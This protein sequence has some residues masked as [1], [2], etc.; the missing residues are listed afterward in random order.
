MAAVDMTLKLDG[1]EGES[2]K[3][4]H[5][6]EIDILSYSFGAT[7]SGTF[8]KGGGGGAGL[9][10][11]QDMVCTMEHNKASPAIMAACAQGDHVASAVLTCRKAGKEQQDFL[12]ITLTNCLLSHYHSTGSG[13]SGSIPTDQF[14][15]NFSKIEHEYK[16]QAA[17]GTLKGSTKKSFDLATA[18]GG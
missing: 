10:E 16:E 9:V 7:N 15:I 5:T 4:K 14:S 2:T 13:Q 3:D 12:I 1:I 17:D 11:M 18:K 6:A 8:G